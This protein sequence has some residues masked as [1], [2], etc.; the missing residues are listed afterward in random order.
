MRERARSP[1]TGRGDVRS[2]R[3]TRSRPFQQRRAYISINGA[4]RPIKLD[5]LAKTDVRKHTHH[6]VTRR[7]HVVV[8]GEEIS[9]PAGP[10]AAAAEPVHPAVQ[11]TP[12]RRRRRT[13]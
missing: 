13:S 12:R 8:Q 2:R 9:W 3:E 10:E 11:E 5:P 4:V 1:R 7:R 6:T